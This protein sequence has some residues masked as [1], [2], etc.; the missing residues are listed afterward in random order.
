[1]PQRP[2]HIQLVQ[3][4]KTCKNVQFQK[5]TDVAVWLRKPC[6][7]GSGPFGGRRPSR[8]RPLSVALAI[9]HNVPFSSATL[10]GIWTFTRRRGRS[11][12][13]AIACPAM[14]Y[15]HLSWHRDCTIDPGICRCG[16][17]PAALL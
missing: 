10:A 5:Q 1:M 13:G 12:S 15:A 2:K 4:S 7:F 16:M 11:R 9:P 3:P 8:A 14:I 17:R 6:P